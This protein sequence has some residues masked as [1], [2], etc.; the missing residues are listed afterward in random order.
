MHLK[1]R[2][3]LYYYFSA[4]FLS[5]AVSGYFLD[6]KEEFIAI[7]V[8]YVGIIGNQLMLFYG[9]SFFI[10]ASTEVDKPKQK[11]LIKKV[12]FFFL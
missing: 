5:F 6:S 12:T 2:I 11:K 10:D 4:L 8:A 9:V 1:K 7:L 3:N